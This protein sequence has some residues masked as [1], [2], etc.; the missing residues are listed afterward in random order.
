MRAHNTHICIYTFTFCTAHM[1]VGVQRCMYAK[2]SY[3]NMQVN[4]LIDNYFIFCK[5]CKLNE[6][7]EPVE[8][9]KSKISAKD[10]KS[11][12]ASCR[13]CSV[14]LQYTK[15]FGC[16]HFLTYIH[17]QPICNRTRFRTTTISGILVYR[18]TN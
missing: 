13:G 5:E 18:H 15:R 12:G 10:S 14:A 7:K 4:R 16:M 8:K 6:Q 2:A 1:Y 17:T 11:F 3:S 9:C